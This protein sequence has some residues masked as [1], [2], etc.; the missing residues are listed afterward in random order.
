MAD[1]TVKPQAI[2]ATD[3]FLV[4]RPQGS[5]TGYGPNPIYRV[6][7]EDI[8]IFASNYI[9][10]DFEELKY[11]FKD[12][13]NQLDMINSQLL[14]TI[15]TITTDHDIRIKVL[16]DHTSKLILDLDE[17]NN[18]IE[19]IIAKTR[20]YFYHRLMEFDSTGAAG[21]MVVRRR[22]GGAMAGF[23]DVEIIEYYLTDRQNIDNIFVNEVLELSSQSGATNDGGFITHRA[24][25]NI[26]YINPL[27]GTADGNRVAFEVSIR[28]SIGNGFPYY[29]RG[30]LNEVRTDIYP[31]FTI[32][33]EEYEEGIEG[34]YD[35]TGGVLTGD[36]II[37][38]TGTAMLH[39]KGT[40]NRIQFEETLS[41]TR[42]GSEVL[43]LENNF[44]HAR[45]SINLNGNRLI[46]L[47]EPSE[48]N[49][50]ATKK[51]V[52]DVVAINDITEDQLFAAGDA[53]AGL[54]SGTTQSRGFFYQSGSLYYK[55]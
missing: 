39:L 8:G 6:S 48:D 26:D 40:A 13:Q 42:G 37:E 16:E 32:S 36:L 41:F 30:L 53:V 2:N 44:I 22:D 18:N 7:A 50:A 34:K 38:K 52:D 27:G 17:T 19:N 21:E 11:E 15:K 12:I 35:K 20:L 24:I 46:N 55:I 25:F 54:S 4:Q 3:Q 45:K 14:T 28:N 23:Q 33:K 43:K 47:A 31:V 29:Q 9:H 10:E 51:Y 49:A 5:S 1:L